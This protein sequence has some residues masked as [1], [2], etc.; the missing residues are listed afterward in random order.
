[1]LELRFGSIQDFFEQGFGYCIVCGNEIVSWCL[2]EYN[3][4]EKCDIEIETIEK[5]QQQGLAT[6]V[7][8]KFIDHGISAGYNEIGWHTF[9]FNKPSVK[10]ALKLGFKKKRDYSCY[11]GTY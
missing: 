5:Y 10:T 9:A 4:P 2:S 1:M 3:T 8:A 7:A 11:S 6:A